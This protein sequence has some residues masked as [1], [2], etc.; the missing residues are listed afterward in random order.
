MVIGITK[1]G[2]EIRIRRPR[3][4]LYANFGKFGS[5]ISLK[6]HQLACFLLSPCISKI[7]KIPQNYTWI[8]APISS[9]RSEL[10]AKCTYWRCST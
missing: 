9:L 1:I 10:K 4:R 8:E 2:L 3:N 5:I 7:F 6:K